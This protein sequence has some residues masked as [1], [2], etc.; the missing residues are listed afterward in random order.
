MD[1]S[2]AGGRD[3]VRVWGAYGHPG[4]LPYRGEGANQGHDKD[5]GWPP[6]L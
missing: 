1:Q 6:L 4:E 2:K 5:V 3:P